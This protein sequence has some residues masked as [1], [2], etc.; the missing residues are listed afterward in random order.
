MC[1][2]PRR[3]GTWVE[4]DG[5]GDLVP[6]KAGET[7]IIG[8]SVDAALGIVFVGEEFLGPQC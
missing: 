2:C 7:P 6:Q 4:T 3:F 1:L 5:S 8:I